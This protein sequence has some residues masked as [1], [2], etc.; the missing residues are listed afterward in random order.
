MK[1][2]RIVGTPTPRLEGEEKA[3][4]QAV[5]AAD[6]TVPDMLWVK[7]LRSPIPYG[8]VKNIDASRALS[9][10]GVKAVISAKDVGDARIGK[11]IY[12]MPLLAQ[13]VVR[14]IGEKVAA[15]AAETKEQ[16]QQAV[17]LIE[18]EYE[19]LEPV[20]DPLEAM[21][22][23]APLLHPDLGSYRGLLHPIET[24][25]NICARLNWKKGNIEEG[26]RQADLVLE[27]TFSTAFMHQAYIE[28]HSCLV[29]ADAD[30]GVEIWASTKSPFNLLEHLET[31]LGL[32]REKIMAHSC[33]IG[34]D[35]GGKG[36]H[37]DIALCYVLSRKAGR[38]VKL[39]LD[40]TEEF[41]AGNPRH[42]AI[43]HV[44][45][46]VKKSGILVA[47]YVNF[48]FDSGAY[49]SYRPQGFLVAAHLAPGPY[50]VP[51]V[52]IEESYVYTNKLPGGYMRG[53]GYTQ[54]SFA[55]ES[56]MDIVARSLGLD[57]AKFRMKNALY[58][59]D[60]TPTGEVFS[61]IRTQQTLKNALEKSGYHRPKAKNVGRGCA[62]AYW[63]S[64]GGESYS[65]V[66][67]DEDGE[68]TLVTA[69]R[70]VG[71]GS[72]TILPQIVAEELRIPA[73]SV[74]LECVDTTRMLKDTGVR[75]SSSTRVH[76]SSAYEAA[77][78]ARRELL[79]TA[80]GLLEAAPDEL[81]LYNAGVMHSKAERR[82]TFAEIAQA[83]GSPI[84]GNGHYQNMKSG[85]EA[86]TVAQVV[87]VEVDPETGEVRVQRVTTSHTVGTIL[88]PMT[89]Q[90]QIDGAIVMGVGYAKL[91]EIP[92][93]NGRVMTANLGDYK[94]PSIRD[95]PV[96]H[97][98]IDQTATGSGPYNSVGIGELPLIP[99]AA[100]IANAVEDASGIRVKSLPVTAEKVLQAKKGR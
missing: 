32:S 42:A 68:V 29:R 72:Y 36:D 1:A 25:S 89:H 4:G 77:R 76:G 28:P 22:P 33:Y 67:I 9:V 90:G 10:P 98:A 16:A 20:F 91:E 96:I 99:M 74:K 38:P 26:F 100:A 18:V 63:P 83:N 43:I 46:G 37:N 17:D 13:G 41:I 45:T 19:E 11:K 34:G 97:T 2:E 6:V 15:V 50:R 44:K 55:L 56:Q 47:Q 66:R 57:P 85:P 80:A 60:E 84:V 81:V 3:S 12:D 75:G 73:A 78:D 71:P 92:V 51:H 31:V 21:K 70:D 93:E 49:A 62:V 95:I 40:Y 54:G 59:G 7:I 88:N 35:F 58:D 94:I 61:P 65:S 8:R 39:V 79:E 23:S 30:G 87:E 14:F 64:H 82:V 24:P 86:P 48:I 53:P 52:L 69:V 27:N 5:Y